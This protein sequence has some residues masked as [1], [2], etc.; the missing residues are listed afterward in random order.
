MRYELSTYQPSDWWFTSV[1]VRLV[2]N[3]QKWLFEIS[4]RLLTPI[5]RVINCVLFIPMVQLILCWHLQMWPNGGVL[6]GGGQ[7][8]LITRVFWW[9]HFPGGVLPGSVGVLPVSVGVLPVSVGV[10]PVSVGVLPACSVLP[11]R[12]NFRPSFLSRPQQG[13]SQ[14][15]VYGYWLKQ[16]CDSLS[17]NELSHQP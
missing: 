14:T 2:P 11:V 10:L 13:M 9:P 3:W 16:S 15:A 4:S 7:F 12:V 5:A 6:N 1:S 17:S 8:V